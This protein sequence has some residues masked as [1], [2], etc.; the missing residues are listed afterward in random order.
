MKKNRKHDRQSKVTERVAMNST[1][2][3]CFWIILENIFEEK[4]ND[5][6]VVFSSGLSRRSY[7]YLIDW[8]IGLL[9][10]DF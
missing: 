2:L 1:M 5:E 9:L 3:Y 6:S 7:M 10:L 4:N 8:L